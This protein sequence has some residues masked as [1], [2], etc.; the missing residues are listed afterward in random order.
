MARMKSHWFRF[1]LRTLLLLLTVL[2][3][4]LGIQVNSVRRQREAV[5]VLSNARASIKYHYQI[6]LP[7]WLRQ[8]EV[9]DYF[10]TVDEVG[11]GY[12]KAGKAAL[13]VLVK[14]PQISNFAFEG[15]GNDNGIT[16]KDLTPLSEL[17][18]LEALRI[19]DAHVNGSIL[20]SLRNPGRLKILTLCKTE[21]DDD[22]LRHLEKMTMLEALALAETH[23]TDAGLV[24]VRDLR[25]LEV[26]WLFDTSITDAALEHLKG[27]KKLTRIDLRNTQVSE[28]G[29]DKLGAALPNANIVWP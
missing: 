11:I 4:W 24:H 6:E 14:L 13:N 19:T 26:I 2:C 15:T 18:Q 29:V 23:I 9:A 17:R 12:P 27:L 5:A 7:T 3:V 28:A 20:A 1:S 21:I 16:D 25:N 8:Y 10:R 22:A